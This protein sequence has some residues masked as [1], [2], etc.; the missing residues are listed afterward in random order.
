M[1]SSKITEGDMIKA[2]QKG[3]VA[4]F[5][6]HQIDGDYRIVDPEFDG[7]TLFLS[8]LADSNS[9][10]YLY[11]L[12]QGANLFS[13]NSLG[14][15]V[16]HSIAF[17]KDS[18][19]LKHIL[20]ANLSCIEMLNNTAISGETPLHYS[21]LF[22]NMGYFDALIELGA[23]V[24]CTDNEGC[25]PLHLACII[26]FNDEKDNLH[27]VK[28]LLERGANPLLKTKLGNYPLA[29]AINNDLYRVARL[30]WGYQIANKDVF[31]K[32]LND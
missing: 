8:S 2:L 1:L 26:K 16:L 7:D 28:T 24:N 32:V 5:Q 12:E 30:L 14:E 6:A 27:I 9:E 20:K 17:S 25:S 21:I 19:R 13:L 23:E 4:F 31:S 10:L 29:L 18:Q 22:E 3:D 15:N 11:F